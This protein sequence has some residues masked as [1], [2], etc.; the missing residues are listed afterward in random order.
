MKITGFIMLITL[1]W[2]VCSLPH[3]DATDDY[4]K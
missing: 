3:E 1:I 4:D 2:I